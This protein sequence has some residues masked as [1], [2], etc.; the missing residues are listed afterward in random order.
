MTETPSNT[1]NFGAGSVLARWCSLGYER[2]C[3]CPRPTRVLLPWHTDLV[4]PRFPS[5]IPTPSSMF[6]AWV[7][8]R[9]PPHPPHHHPQDS[10]DDPLAGGGDLAGLSE[11]TSTALATSRMH[12]WAPS[13]NPS[14]L[15]ELRGLDNVPLIDVPGAAAADIWGGQPL[16]LAGLGEESIRVPV[17]WGGAEFT[18]D[19]EAP[20]PWDV[21]GLVSC[22]PTPSSSLLLSSLHPQ[23]STPETSR[24]H[25]HQNPNPETRNK[26]RVRWYLVG[27]SGGFRPGGGGQTTR[28]PRTRTLTHPHS[29]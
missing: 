13:G 22:S 29:E 18:E 8:K 4:V 14:P 25:N 24:P 3:S 16:S 10:W 27:G 12:S 2:D 17:S 1:L 21:A 20:M 19:N 15:S 23:P 9:I 6:R 5:A 7:V 28:R 26:K 11:M